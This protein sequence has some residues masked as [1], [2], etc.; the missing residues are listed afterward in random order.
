MLSCYPEKRKS[1]EG[2]KLYSDSCAPKIPY[3]PV[4]AMIDERVEA[5]KT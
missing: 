4:F 1:C 2:D 3:E 5:R